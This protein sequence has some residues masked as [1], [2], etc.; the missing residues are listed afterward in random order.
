[1]TEVSGE[2]DLTRLRANVESA[3]L[4]KPEVVKL[5]VTALLAGEHILLEDV[6]GVGKTLIA[7]AVAR[8]VDGHFSRLQFTPDLL[9]SDI[10]GSSIYNSSSGQFTFNRGPIFANV[11]LADEI[12]RAPPRTQ[13][14]LLEAMGEGQVS[15]DGETHALP[16][17]LLVIATQN[18]F[19]FEGTYLLPESQLDR[20]L[21][22]ITV[23]YPDRDYELQLLHS[24][25][26]G[27]PVDELKPAVSLDQVRALQRQVREVNFE[28]SLVRYLLDI[29][30]ATRDSEA[31][32]VGVSTRGA[33]AYY[34]A[35][36][37]I[38]TV[39]NRSHVIPDDI[40]RLAIPVMAHRI[41]PR[42]MLPGADRSASEELVRRL[43]GQIRVP[44]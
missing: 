32:Q 38:A 29:V 19:E 35:A 26:V 25:R 15:V 11:V 8:S 17:P 23:G 36:Q 3:V 5:V 41:V 16:D 13:S 40:K 28:E 39:E 24:H 21:L 12:N 6:P 37:A 9:P 4:G 2:L 27:E 14:A 1:M 42:G 44:T 7:K 31:V 33:L 18:P 30:H 43:L 22:R 20:F 10:T 34:R